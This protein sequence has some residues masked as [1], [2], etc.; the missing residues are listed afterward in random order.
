ML[1]FLQAKQIL[2]KYA[3]RAGT[4]ID[5][6]TLPFFVKEV[7][8]QLLFQGTYGNL[9]K[10]CFMAVRNC[11]TVPYELE[12]IE[13]IKI[14]GWVGSAWDR[15][16]EFHSAGDIPGCTP[17]GNAAFEEP[18]YYPTVYDIPAGGARVG[19]MGTCVEA[20]DAHIIV[21]G[22]DLTG[23]EI[24]TVHNGQQIVGE[25][26]TIRRN[27]IRYTQA[28]FASITGIVK[29]PTQGYVNLLWLNLPLNLKGFL[30]DYSPL[31]EVP[32][33]RRYRLT[34]PCNEE[35]LRVSALGRIRLKETYTDNDLIP[36]ENILAINMAGQAVQ[37][38][39]N[40]NMPV[41]LASAS[42]GAQTIENENSYKKPDVGQPMEVFIPMSG[43]AV[44][45]INVGGG[46]PW[47]GGPNAGWGRK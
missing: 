44:P 4:C 14:D 15:F 26:L 18:N 7:L 6:P 5:D 3:S 40:R 19:C 25:Y 39:K 27:E 28:V 16:F 47:W 11:F 1:T 31:E 38:A 33:Y 2:A 12:T 22:I 10:F 42:I 45:S 23:R 43:G 8:Q 34:S 17:L 37:E 35:R 46:F 13:K 30:A 29:S 36:F 24:I 41:A 9:R 21:K 32:A 20:E